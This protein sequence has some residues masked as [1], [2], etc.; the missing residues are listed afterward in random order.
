MTKRG[1]PWTASFVSAVVLLFGCGTRPEETTAQT[2]ASALASPSAADAGDADDASSVE[3]FIAANYYADSDIQH[4]FHTIFGEQVDCIDFY[5][6]PSVRSSLASGVPVPAPASPLDLPPAISD[7]PP[8]PDAFMGAPDAD[9]N[10]RACS[11]N[12]VPMIRPTVGEVQAAGGIAA[13]Q[14]RHRARPRDANQS[15]LQYDCYE[16]P[17]QTVLNDLL[18]MGDNYDHAVG[19]QH[20]DVAYFIETMSVNNPY[21]YSQADHSI[22]QL[23]LQTGG[24]EYWLSPYSCDPPTESG[25]S[26][27]AVQ[28]IEVGWVVGNNSGDTLTHLFSYTTVDGYY[29]EAWYAGDPGSPW[30]VAPGATYTMGMTL[31]SS[32]SSPYHELS[33]DVYNYSPGYPNWYVIMNG[34][35]IGWYPVGPSGSSPGYAGIM[36]THADY[37]Q[38]GGEVFSAST[39][40]EYTTTEMGTGTEPTSGTY[41]SAAYVRDVAYFESIEGCAPEMNASL[42]Y[43]SG[44]PAFEEDDGNQ[45]VCGYFAGNGFTKCS[46]SCP[47]GSS[48]WDSFLYYGG[49]L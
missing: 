35:L 34:Q 14:N 5:A 40:A 46:S 38:V 15:T 12:T 32:N 10:A 27:E 43:I 3:A 21:L 25:G 30:R 18:D 42:S 20:V 45:G 13:F 2:S 49:A 36:R 7:V 41:T 16:I 6:Q 23:W 44:L 4:S 28:S 33:F 37:L 47:P 11:G 39:T 17:N 29:Q 24:C 19:Y 1:V 9:G 8:G 26:N 48:S 31:S 22:G